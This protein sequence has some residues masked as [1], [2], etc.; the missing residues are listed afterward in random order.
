MGA[1]VPILQKAGQLDAR[2][3]GLRA[4]ILLGA[5]IAGGV[6]GSLLVGLLCLN[7]L[8]TTG[9]L[10]VLLGLGLVFVA[11]GLTCRGWRAA[12]ASIGGV[13]LVLMLG[14]PGQD[15]FW[16]RL[17]G[18]VS[19]VLMLAEDATGVV[20][21]VPVPEATWMVFVDGLAHSWLPFDREEGEH[22][23]LG[24]IPVLVHP[25]PGD[26]A[27]IG[28]G[29]GDTAWAAG[30]RP[31]T[32][33]ISVFEVSGV[34]RDLLGR[35]WEHRPFAELGAL[36]KDPRV[37]L[38]IADGRHALLHDRHRYDVI[39]IDA[40]EPFMPY[41]GNLYSAEFFRLGA[42]R[43]RPGGLFCTYAP[44]PRI[45]R[46]FAEAFPHVLDFGIFL[47]GSQQPIPLEPA[48]WKARLH[49]PQVS[50]YLGPAVVEWAE[51]YVDPATPPKPARVSKGDLN[52]DLFPRDEL[53]LP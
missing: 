3:S 35:F 2:T 48:T 20:A 31:R 32:K 52:R 49:S 7:A 23:L 14:L 44:T 6:C 24:A 13:L 38:R 17:H 34:Q 45:T 21:L 11:I 4:G 53:L 51:E 39:E 12:F 40:L 15:R 16:S 46:S 29:S 42:E 5:N 18:R 28:L 25:S 36:L 30:C 43:L 41:S 47:L 33:R 1:S 26:V 27:V 37:E 10:R 22:S 50:A 19:D 8:G 9:S